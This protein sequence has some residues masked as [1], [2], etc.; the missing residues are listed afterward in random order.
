MTV[1]TLKGSDQAQTPK[2]GRKLTPEN[3]RQMAEAEQKINDL[4]IGQSAIVLDY[5][6]S[7]KIRLRT[8][9]S[10]IQDKD[11]AVHAPDKR[12]VVIITRLL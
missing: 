4:E 1:K 12:S 8:M 9:V 10:R 5:G 6:R 7:F 2:R 3:K 11:F